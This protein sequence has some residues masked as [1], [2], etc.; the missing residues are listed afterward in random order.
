MAEIG[1][2]EIQALRGMITAGWRTRAIY[3]GVRTGLFDTLGDEPRDAAGL[4]AELNL[5]EETVFRVLRALST[6]SVCDHVGPTAFT[7]TPMG[8]L[9]RS[10]ADVSLRSLSIHWGGRVMESLGTIGHTLETGEPGRGKGDFAGLHAN[11]F[12]SQAFNRTMAEQSR[13]VAKVLADVHDFAPYDL[14]MDVGGGFG[15]LLTEVLLANPTLQGAIFDLLAVEL[16]ADKY[17]AEAGL[18]GRVRFI[19]GSFFE[20]VAPGADC[21]VLK[22]ILHDWD[23]GECATIMANCRSAMEK[24]AHLLIVERIMPELV[25]A[26]NEDVVRQDLVMMPING[27]ERT[28]AEMEKMG[29]DGGFELIDV[30]PLTE[31]CSLI[32]MRAV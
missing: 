21:V 9:L 13:P 27:K 2:D 22:F 20:F 3:E 18:H 7:I 4:A 26:E 10:D 14:V 12:D 1:Q 28:L 24:G 32:A 17:L 30:K 31:G 29:S 5:D 25:Q 6:L 11:S 15:G 19:G 8:R 16:G 23:D